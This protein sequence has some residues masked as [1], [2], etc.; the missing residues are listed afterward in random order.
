MTSTSH[1][2]VSIVQSVIVNTSVIRR[3]VRVIRSI[4]YGVSQLTM[5]DAVAPYHRKSAYGYN[6]GST[7]IHA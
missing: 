7:G 6:I 3:S 2:S 1:A 4:L 5:R